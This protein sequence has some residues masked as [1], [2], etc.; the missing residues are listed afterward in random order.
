MVLGFGAVIGSGA[1][2]GAFEARSDCVVAGVAT[3]VLV[4]CVVSFSAMVH[5]YRVQYLYTQRKTRRSG[6][7][8]NRPNRS[9]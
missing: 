3:T 6:L 9:N 2:A 4:F 8:I 1:G 7:I 5:P